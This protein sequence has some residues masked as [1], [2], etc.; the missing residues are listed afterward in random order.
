MENMVVA[1]G[2]NALIK[3]GQ[4]GTI[5]EQ[6]A[7]ARE[8]ARHL[9]DLMEK[10]YNLVLTH[11]NGPQ[12]GAQLLRNELAR[13]Q[14]PPNPLGICVADTQGEMGYML[15][16]VFGNELRQRGIEREVVTVITQVIVD[17]DDPSFSSP[18]KPIGMFYS[19]EE[20]RKLMEEHG[21]T[22]V[23]DAGRGWRRV[24][25]SP[26]PKEIVE[27]DVIKSLI[28]DG[29][30]VIACGGGGLPVI[31]KGPI[32]DGVEAVVDK[33]YASSV[34]AVQLGVKRFMILTGVDKVYRNFTSPE[35][36]GIDEITLDEIK[37]LAREGHF[38]PGSMGPKIESAIY[39]LEKGGEEVIITDIHLASMAIEGKAGTRII[40]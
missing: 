16:Q 14:V 20:A 22:M 1:I 39:F 3:K 32:L 26:R 9:V 6:F 35:R 38:P 29:F 37:A 5:Y 30:M 11:G 31:R 36:E 27:I 19:E 34:L 24:V 4:K 7:N 21:W 13:E 17:P 33:D 23:N 10:G 40:R 25:P 8:T 18:T 28:R 12:V 15:Q 2:G